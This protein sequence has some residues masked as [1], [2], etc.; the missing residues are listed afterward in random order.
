[1]KK[2]FQKWFQYPAAFIC[3]ISLNFFLIH[4]MPG[5]PLVNLLGEEG[6]YYL[7]AHK[8]ARLVTLRKEHGLDLPSYQRYPQYLKRTVQGDLGWSH[9]YGAKVSHL[10]WFRLKGT[11]MLLF[12]AVMVST[13]LGGFFGAHAGWKPRGMI[14]KIMTPGFL[15]VYSIPGYCMGLMLL[16]LSFWLDDFFPSCFQDNAFIWPMIT[17]IFHNTAYLY[18]IMKNSLGQELGQP[19]V[20]TAFSRGISDRGVLFHHVLKNAL[21]PYIAVVALNLGFMLGGTLLVEIVFSYQG[22]GTLIYDAVFSR[23]YPLLSGSFLILSLG[24]ISA[25]AMAELVHAG[26]DPRVRNGGSRV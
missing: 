4:M 12:P 14:N 10:I 22:M 3:I 1:M 26:L 6:Y 25:N 18:M 16:T 5:D 21:P 20:L 19:Y 13:L 2:N 11:L 23:D 17:I 7:S 24:V 15:I 8:P 9:H